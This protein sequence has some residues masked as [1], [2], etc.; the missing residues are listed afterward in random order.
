MIYDVLNQTYEKPLNSGDYAVREME[1]ISLLNRMTLNGWLADEEEL[2]RRVDG[3]AARRLAAVEKLRSVYGMPTHEPDKFKLKRKADWPQPW[4]MGEVRSLDG[5]TQ[6][7]EGFAVRIPGERKL[8]PWSTGPGRAALMAAFGQAGA[9][10]AALLEAYRKAEGR[11]AKERIKEFGQAC[12]APGAPDDAP[13]FPL[14]APSNTNPDGL[15]ALGKDVLGADRD[16][17]TWYCA[18]RRK[19]FPTVLAMFGHIPGVVDLVE[20]ILLA[21]G[22]RMKFAEIK[23]YVTPSGRVH[24][25]LGAAQA[26]GRFPFKEPSLTNVGMRG[27]AIEERSPMIADPGQVLITID[28]SQVDVRAVAIHSQDPEL[29]KMLQPGEDYHTMMAMV[30]FGDP[31]KRSAGKPLSHGL[32][33]GMGAYALSQRNGLDQAFVEEAM[34]NLDAKLPDRAQWLRDVRAEGEENGF[35]NNGFGRIMRL[36]P[37]QAYTQAPALMGQGL[38]RDLVC[39]SLLRAVALADAEGKNIR[40][41]L[42]L[43][44]HDELIGSFPAGE[45]EYWQDLLKRAFTWEFRGVPILGDAGSPAH[46]W[47]EAGH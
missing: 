13:V 14:T 29:I 22:A 8:S 27:V 5:E 21:T 45:A 31:S 1:I 28:A 11:Q 46:R 36:E 47:S 33:Y 19:A 44:V 34:S 10:K 4:T 18:K 17:L 20:T 32:P 26:S 25:S 7:R 41:H 6:E 38:A 15:L 43:I 30:F 9:T 23:K 12:L 3:E 37:S 35:L 42:R 16:K 24:A 40:P 2:D 39:E